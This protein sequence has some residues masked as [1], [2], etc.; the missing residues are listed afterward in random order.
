MAESLLEQ[1]EALEEKIVNQT[2]GAAS[3]CHATKDV[4]V[5]AVIPEFTGCPGDM[6][7]H[8]FLEAVNLIVRMQSWGEDD[9]KHSTKLKLGGTTRR[10][11]LGSTEL[12]G[13][14]G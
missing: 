12:H 13:Y 7:V 6:R 14:I 3:R 8:E 5:V 4:S 2:A 9:K 10:L 11:H 1:I